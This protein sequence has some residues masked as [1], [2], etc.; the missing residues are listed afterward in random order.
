MNKCVKLQRLTYVF[1][2]EVAYRNQQ[3]R[4]VR[5]KKEREILGGKDQCDS[6]PET[7]ADS[8]LKLCYKKLTLF[9]AG[10]ASH[11]HAV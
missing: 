6:I 5:A 4:N 3:A 10:R 11:R 1:E 7:F 2:I 8:H 9:L